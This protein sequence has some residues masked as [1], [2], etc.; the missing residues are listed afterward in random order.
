MD[1]SARDAL[2]QG[3]RR[4]AEG[5]RGAFDA[6]FVALWPVLRRFAE[7]ALRDPADADD[8]AQSALVKV[9]ARVSQFDA[10]RDA[11]AWAIAIASYECRTL[12][13]RSLRRREDRTEAPERAAP[14][15]EDEAIEADLHAAV[16][17]ACGALSPADAETLLAAARGERPRS[18]AFRKR[19]ERALERLRKEW[20]TRHGT[21]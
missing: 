13:K 12:R 19:L 14:S 3:M 6:V 16:G 11:L 4:L 15:A 9:F 8:A 21:D 7:R 2:Q 10:R 1:R 5:D 20:R 18:A 17:E